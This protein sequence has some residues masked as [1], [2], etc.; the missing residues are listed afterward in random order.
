MSRI[1]GRTNNKDAIETRNSL[2]KVADEKYVLLQSQGV[3]ATKFL[4]V[5]KNL[6]A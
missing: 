5:H 6:K 2:Q 1:V 4:S 3:D